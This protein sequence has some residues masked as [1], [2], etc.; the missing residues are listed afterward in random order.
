VSL[1]SQSSTASLALSISLPRPTV[2]ISS[3]I[4]EV[5][6]WM[7]LASGLL[8]VLG[9]CYI[10][11][12]LDTLLWKLNNESNLCGSLKVGEKN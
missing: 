11:N 1:G 12:V 4:S 3:L 5:N 7:I 8:Q 6:G 2:C 10:E 9:A